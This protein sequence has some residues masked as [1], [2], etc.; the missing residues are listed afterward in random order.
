M[1]KTNSDWS[2]QKFLAKVLKFIDIYNFFFQK[3]CFV[4]FF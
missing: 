2:L 3:I 1:I 4:R